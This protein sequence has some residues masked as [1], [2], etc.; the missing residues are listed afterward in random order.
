VIDGL[1]RT[2]VYPRGPLHAY[3][4][5]PPGPPVSVRVCPSHLGPSLV[6]VATG[7]GKIVTVMLLVSEHPE[8]FVSTTLKIHIPVIV[9]VIF[10]ILSV[11]LAILPFPPGLGIMLHK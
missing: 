5:I 11:G 10:V 6:A 7:F 8:P 9:H 2:E 1:C 4:V 3:E